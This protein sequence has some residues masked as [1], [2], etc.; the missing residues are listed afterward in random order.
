M[1][2]DILAAIHAIASDNSSG[3]AALTRKAAEVLARTDPSWFGAVAAGLAEAQP[4]MVSVSNLIEY[5]RR[6]GRPQDFSKLLEDAARRVVEIAGDLIAD[7]AVVMTHSFSETVLDSLL[8]AHRRGRKFRVIATESRPLREGVELARRLHASGLSVALI[9]DAATARFMPE[10]TLVLVGADSVDR[11]GVVNKVGT[12]LLALAAHQHG[13]PMYV[14]CTSYKFRM[15]NLGSPPESPK[16]S[17]EVESTVPA[18]NYYFET[19]PMNLITGVISELG[20][21]K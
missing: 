8:C 12:T 1:P 4:A 15:E 16:N 20:T 11:D 17:G 14:V 19:T 6:G 7:D 21:R 5:V 3:A 18:L 2:P 10:T 13:I 9:V